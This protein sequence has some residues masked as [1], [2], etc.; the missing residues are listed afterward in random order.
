MNQNQNAVIFT[1]QGSQQMVPMTRTPGIPGLFAKLICLS[2]VKPSHLSAQ[3]IL[4]N[5]CFVLKDVELNEKKIDRFKQVCGY[6]PGIDTVPASFIQTLFIGVVA[7]F[8]GSSCFPINPMGL[9]QVGQSLELR[10]PLAAGQRLDLFCSLLD[11]TQT[12]R[13][14]HTRFE[15]KAK[16]AR[17][18]EVVWQ[19]TALYFTRAKNPEKKPKKDRKEEIA[20]AVKETIRVPEN[21]GRLYAGVSGDYNPHH[22]YG[23]TAKFIGFKQPIAHGMW[24]LA[25]AGASL[26]KEFGHPPTLEMEGAL[27]LP[28]FL[29]ATVTLGYETHGSQAVFEIRDQEKGIPHLKGSFRF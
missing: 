13:G 16:P 18:E 8:I 25:R 27:K 4:E 1:P 24:S 10:H 7:K 5:V 22:L 12:D 28:I 6:D 26:E 17:K 11:M 20:L 23:W 21:I 15:F 2:M 29:P 19:G 3:T 14:I 9:I